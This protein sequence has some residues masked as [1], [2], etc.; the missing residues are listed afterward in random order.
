MDRISN[1]DYDREEEKVNVWGNNQ[2]EL[3]DRVYFIHISSSIN[4][5]DSWYHHGGYGMVI[6]STGEL[7][8]ATIIPYVAPHCAAQP[9][10]VNCN[11]ICG[12]CLALKQWYIYKDKVLLHLHHRRLF[13]LTGDGEFSAC[14][15]QEQPYLYLDQQRTMELVNRERRMNI[16]LQWSSRI[17]KYSSYLSS[18]LF[19]CFP[20]FFISHPYNYWAY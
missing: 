3:V 12:S 2:Q 14:L 9:G 18:F 19:L 20:Q 17:R 10:T 15:R 1:I 4:I 16:I 7:V 13:P 6:K 11:T 8:M 5:N